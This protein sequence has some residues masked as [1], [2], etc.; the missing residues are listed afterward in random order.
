MTMRKPIKPIVIEFTGTPN[1]GKTTLIH[2]LSD[3]LSG[4]GYNVVVTQED[5]EIVPKEIPKKTWI[6]NV[7]IALNQLQT[8]LEAQ[9]ST[10][11]I[12][13]LDRGYYDAIFWAKFLQVQGICSQLESAFLITI[14]EEL[15]HEFSFQPDYL[16]VLDVS[17]EES[18]KRR[19]AQSNEPTTISNDSFLISYKKGL[20]SFCKRYTSDSFFYLD[21]SDLSIDET[22]SI[23]LEIV[24]TWISNL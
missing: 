3:F 4:N 11:D 22:V 20:A 17:V 10:A 15:N 13:L 19:A 16:F 9:Y 7:W 12:I 23:G 8:L 1:S 24:N 21:N 14:L 2:K 6:R 18:L 5:A